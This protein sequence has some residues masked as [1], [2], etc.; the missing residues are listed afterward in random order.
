MGHFFGLRW[1]AQRDTA[2]LATFALAS[3]LS[4]TLNRSTF[5]VA[6]LTKEKRCGANFP[7]SKNAVLS[8]FCTPQSWRSVPRN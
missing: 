6:K 5:Y 3:K 7:P 8:P 2:L 4:G 1:Q